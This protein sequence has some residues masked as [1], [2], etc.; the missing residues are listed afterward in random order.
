[1]KGKHYFNIRECNIVYVE[2]RDIQK[3]ITHIMSQS[4]QENNN[5]TWILWS[6]ETDGSLKKIAQD[7]DPIKLEKYIDYIG[8]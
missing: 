1:M 5:K 2:Y 7:E 4:L 3:N 6:I 8:E